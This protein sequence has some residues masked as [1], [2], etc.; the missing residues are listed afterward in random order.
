M[1]QTVTQV[2]EE[3]ETLVVDVMLPGHD[4]RTTASRLFINTRQRL[5]DDGGACFI[6]GKAHTHDDPLEAHHHPIERSFA[7]MIDWRLFAADCRAGKWGP[8][9]AAFDWDAFLG[10][11]PFNPYAFVDD[12]RVNGLLLCKAHHTR[13]NEGVHTLPFPIWIAQKYGREGF[14]FSAIEIIHHPGQE[15]AKENA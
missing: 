2:H 9:C 1:T 8:A 10:A 6:C 3:K 13:P 14:Q 7:E 5:I 12:M 11:Q 15:P 4:P